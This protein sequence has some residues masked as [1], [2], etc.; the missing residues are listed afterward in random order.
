MIKRLDSSTKPG[1]S[2]NQ[3]SYSTKGGLQWCLRQTPDL[4]LAS[5]YLDR[6]PFSS[7]LFW[8]N[9]HLTVICPCRS[10][11]GFGKNSVDN[12]RD[13]SPKKILWPIFDLCDLER[14]P[15]EWLPKLTISCP[16]PLDCWCQ[17]ASTSIQSFS[18]YR[19]Y[20]FSNKRTDGRTDR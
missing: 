14:W 9:E 12:F 3:N 2:S 4:T 8:H 13:I 16:C 10:G 19:V 5:C 17:F 11:A 18:K 15:A 1:H 20:N 6:W 7:R